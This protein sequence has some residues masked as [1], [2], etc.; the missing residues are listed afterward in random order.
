[1]I[2]VPQYLQLVQW[3]GVTDCEMHVRTMHG[4]PNLWLYMFGYI[5]F[6]DDHHTCNGT[7]IW[8]PYWIRAQL[9]S[10]ERTYRIAD[11]L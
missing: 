7:H 3:N 1:M 2:W 6:D 9:E 11:L 10:Q 5:S 8:C 4:D